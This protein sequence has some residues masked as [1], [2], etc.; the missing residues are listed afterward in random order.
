VVMERGFSYFRI[1]CLLTSAN[2]SYCASV[3]LASETVHFW[4]ALLES[5][6]SI[7]IS[8]CSIEGV[9]GVWSIKNRLS[10][11]EINHTN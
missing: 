5:G 10:L 8:M 6:Y 1:I 9:E 7:G 2:L 4:Q 3:G 11:I